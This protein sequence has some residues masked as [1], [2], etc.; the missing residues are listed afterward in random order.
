MDISYLDIQIKHY[1][2]ALKNVRSEYD[3]SM[4]HEWSKIREKKL[5]FIKEIARLKKLQ[6]D[7]LVSSVQERNTSCMEPRRNVSREISI[8]YNDPKPAC[9][10]AKNI[11]AD[12]KPACTVIE[13]KVED[14]ITYLETFLGEAVKVLWEQWV[15]NYPT[16]YA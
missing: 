8:I 12:C 9:P 3:K 1:E 15:E 14:M 5:Y 16:L 11:T 6:K 2:Q 13:T 4:I 7:K 10:T